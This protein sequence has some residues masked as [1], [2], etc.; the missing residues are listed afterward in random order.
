MA[1]KLYQ[2]IYTLKGLFETLLHNQ[3]HVGSAAHARR[4][5]HRDKRADNYNLI[6][7]GFCTMQ[8]HQTNQI[9]KIIISEQVSIL[10]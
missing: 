3:Q 4:K 5:N 8:H 10:K 6:M 7:F 2:N 9:L 1:R